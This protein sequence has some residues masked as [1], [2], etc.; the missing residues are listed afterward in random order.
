MLPEFDLLIP[1]TVEEACRMKK[2]TGAKVLAGGTDLFVEM[3]NG[4]YRRRS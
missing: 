3:H 4:S 1:L 2:E